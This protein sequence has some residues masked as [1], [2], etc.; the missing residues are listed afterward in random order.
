V[1]TYTKDHVT[2]RL[3]PKRFTENQQTTQPGEPARILIVDDEASCRLGFRVALEVAGYEV[4]EA[5]DGEQALDHLRTE[6]ADLALLDLHMPLLDGMEMLQCLRN[7]GIDVPVVVITAHGSVPRASQAMK[8][9]AVDVLPKPVT[10][11]ALRQIAFEAL[12]RRVH[13]VHE[14]HPFRPNSLAAAAH[15]FSETLIV[16]RKAWQQGQFRLAEELVDRALELDPESAEAHTLRGNVEES[17]GSHHSAYQSYRRAL[18]HDRH[19]GP[20]LDGMRRYCE[21]FGLDLNNR[22]INPVAE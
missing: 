20:A 5:A 1:R 2:D 11:A 3:G 13:L 14:Q 4:A 16:A 6:P 8:L 10:P 21:R 15:R 18:S 19:H 17:L 22:L 7:E 12:M 9:G